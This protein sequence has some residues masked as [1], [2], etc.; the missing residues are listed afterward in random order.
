MNISL[1]MKLKII[2]LVYGM[3]FNQFAKIICYKCISD[4]LRFGIDYALKTNDY[5]TNA[6]YIS[7]EKIKYIY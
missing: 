6:S 5:I 1:K 2:K 3:N 7:G 4:C